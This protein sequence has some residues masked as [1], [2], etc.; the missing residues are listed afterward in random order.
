VA[1]A[2]ARL[3]RTE[4]RQAAGELEVLEPVQVIVEV[5][6]LGK[7]A[8]AAARLGLVDRA[9]EQEGL[10]GR[11]LDEAHEQLDRRGLPRAVRA[12]V[13][14]HLAARHVERDVLHAPRDAHGPVVPVVTRQRA[15]VDRKG[16]IGK[17]ISVWA[18][19][20]VSGRHAAGVLDRNEQGQ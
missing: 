14:H 16:R 8:D 18:A 13:A 5:R 9:A 19:R 10:P 11:P 15:H 1:A 2:L 12:E 3:V 20:L 17:P 4:A 6:L 7:E